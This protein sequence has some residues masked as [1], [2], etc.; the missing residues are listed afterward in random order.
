MMAYRA[1]VRLYNEQGQAFPLTPKMLYKQMREDG[2]LSDGA[3]TKGASTRPKYIDGKSQRLLWI[4]RVHIDADGQ[5]EE[6]ME[7]GELQD[8]PDADVPG[9]DPE[10]TILDAG[11][12]RLCERGDPLPNL[13]PGTMDGKE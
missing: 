11:Q 1:V 8:V 10:Y 12:V 13:P 7:L 2:I 6:Q 4:E 3:T 9:S 5:K